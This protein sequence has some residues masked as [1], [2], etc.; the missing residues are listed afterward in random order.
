MRAKRPEGSRPLHCRKQTPVAESV[1]TGDPST[2]ERILGDDFLGV[3]LKGMLYHKAKLIA[4]T[5]NAPQY[6]VSNRPNEVKV[7]FYGDTAI[8]QGDET[9]ER[10]TVSVDALCG[11]ILG[12]GNMDTGKS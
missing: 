4:D 3:D 11:P 12:F 7:R 2:V 5:R 8:A 6:F 9:W 1:A 10:R